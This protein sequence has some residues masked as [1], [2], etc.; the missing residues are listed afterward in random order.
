MFVISLADL[1]SQQG[2]WSLLKI[3]KKNSGHVL[4]SN[5]QVDKLRADVKTIIY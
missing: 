5:F 4:E 2:L 3:N 1:F